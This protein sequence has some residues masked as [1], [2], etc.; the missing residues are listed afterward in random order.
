MNW[1]SVAFL[2]SVA[3]F[4]LL[5]GLRWPGSPAEFS[6]LN[7]V[8]VG[9]SIIAI[10]WLVTRF[11]RNGEGWEEAA[12]AN[13]FLGF[14]MTLLFLVFDLIWSAGGIDEVWV[15]DFVV[16]LGVG[17]SF[18]VIGL[19][20]RQ[21]SVLAGK[22]AP[23]TKTEATPVEPGSAQEWVEAAKG[24]ADR[25][26]A[27]DRSIANLQGAV[28]HATPDQLH[29]IVADFSSRFERAARS[30]EQSVSDVS[31]SMQKS[32]RALES[33]NSQA[34]TRLSEALESL[35][36]GVETTVQDL[37]RAQSELGAALQEAVSEADVTRDLVKGTVRA[38]AEGWQEHL[39]ETRRIMGAA[40]EQVREAAE[41]GLAAMGRATERFES[42]ADGIAEQVDAL[43]DPAER[44]RGLWSVMHDEERILTESLERLQDSVGAMSAAAASATERIE[45]LDV[46]GA[47]KAVDSAAQESAENLVTG[48]AA[49]SETLANEAN[50]IKK[51]L[52][53]F[54]QVVEAQIKRIEKR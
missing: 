43:P 22:S 32:A 18:S 51:L 48:S 21:L 13:Y 17:L 42:L 27:L 24:I 11:G 29:S 4:G 3:V 25:L 39:A 31:G 28:T 20:F 53:E 5:F 54:Y 40:G 6:P 2:L 10:H 46:G 1:R 23:S 30:L 12:D 45:A 26:S 35:R 41:R 7:K 14:I 50:A 49:M 44:I 47:A 34:H 15:Q 9:G 37:N 52:D 8:L 38:E 16:D 36:H 33:V 19:T